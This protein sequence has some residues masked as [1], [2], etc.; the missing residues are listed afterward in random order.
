MD[1]HNVVRGSLTASGTGNVTFAATASGKARPLSVLPAGWKGGIR[2]DDPNGVDWELSMCTALGNN[3]F[4]RDTL[5][6][7]STGS[8]V[9]LAVGTIGVQTLVA[10]QLNAFV[11]RASVAGTYAVGQTLTASYPAGIVGTIQF[12]RTMMAA[13]YTKTLISGAVASA[14]NSLAYTIQATVDEGYTIGV[15][16]SNQVSAVT[17]GSVPT[18]T[19]TVSTVFR[20]IYTQ[21]LGNNTQYN[22]RVAVRDSLRT[23]IILRNRNA[24]PIQYAVSTSANNVRS[25]PGSYARLDPGQEVYATGIDQW[26]VQPF[27]YT[28]ESITSSGTTATVTLTNHRLTTGQTISMYSVTPSDYRWGGVITV[29]DAN[30]FTYQTSLSNIAAATVQGKFVLEFLTVEVELTGAL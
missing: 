5:M 11:S 27:I 4:S 18:S 10:Q 28:T 16:C 15:D 25:S 21:D 12:T 17:G 24:Q 8:F 6:H 19:A 23:S 14:V 30:T 29:I 7:S 20:S 2:F 1:H 26:W 13:P 22:G 9:N 3:V